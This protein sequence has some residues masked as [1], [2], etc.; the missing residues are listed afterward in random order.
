[1]FNG[2]RKVGRTH[3]PQWAVDSAGIYEF[4]LISAI[5]AF[6][7]ASLFWPGMPMLL[8]TDNAGEAATL[9]RGSCASSMGGVLASTF[10]AAAASYCTPVWVEEVRSKYNIADPPSRVCH[11]LGMMP[12]R[13][14]R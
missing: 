2:E 11:L 7:A 8:C 3:L 9:V 6:H 4:E 1:M 10:W 13:S 14:R 5:Y 12:C